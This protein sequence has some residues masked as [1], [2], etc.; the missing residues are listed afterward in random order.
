ML[1]QQL[2]QRTEAVIATLTDNPSTWDEAQAWR[3]QLEVLAGKLKEALNE[4][5]LET[6]PAGESLSTEAYPAWQ[7]PHLYRL[8]EA[9]AYLHVGRPPRSPAASPGDG[10]F[11]PLFVSTGEGEGGGQRRPPRILALDSVENEQGDCR[12][13]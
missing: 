7:Y 13:V 5:V 8:T 2:E 12:H 3:R 9:R 1:E 6:L 10:T 4:A 11:P